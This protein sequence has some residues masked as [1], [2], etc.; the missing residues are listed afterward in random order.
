MTKMAIVIGAGIG[1]LCTAIA[2][3]KEGWKVRVFDKAS[4]LSSVGAGIVLAANAIKVLEK[5][6]VAR[7]VCSKGAQVGKAEVRTWDGKLIVN[8][9]ISEQAA[10]YG[11]HS[12]LVHRALLQS[13][14]LEKLSAGSGV[15]LNKKVLTVE[16]NEK[17][18]TALFTDGTIEQGDLL[19]GAD[20]IHSRIYCAARNLYL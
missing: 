3:Q 16:Q 1:G 6:G 20:G 13:I 19:I 18:V 10:R 5:L 9:P 12:Y 7:D 14:L 2:L 15:Q 4:S 8:L 11:S 17:K